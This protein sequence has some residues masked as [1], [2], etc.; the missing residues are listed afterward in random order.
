MSKIKIVVDP[1]LCIGAASC[2]TV[3]GNFFKMNDEN[4]AVV[5]DNGA[6]APDTDRTYER[7]VEVT[8]AQKE[9]IILA[10]QACPTLAIFVYDED[11]T[12]LFPT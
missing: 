7:E 8:D 2:V 6:D 9:M 4:K 12:L 10:A 11:G 5:I 1:N 3:A